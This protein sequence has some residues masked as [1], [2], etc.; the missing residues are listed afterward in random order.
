MEVIK[1][2]AKTKVV[3]ICSFGNDEVKKI[4][5]AKDDIFASPWIS[6]LIKLFREREEVELTIIA[7]NYYNNNYESFRLGKI[8]V[9]LYKYRISRLPPRAYNLTFNYRTATNSILRIVND[10]K[11][12]I[13]HLHGSENPLYSASA[14]PLMDKYPVLVTI[15]GFVSLS[16]TPKNII[17]RYIRWNRIRFE[18]IINSKASYFTVAT[19]DGV[20]ELKRFQTTA[21]LYRD[22]Y[23]TTKPNISSLDFPIKKYDIVYYARLSKA[24]GIEDLLEAIKIL[25]KTRP[26][27]KV[28]V[29]GGGSIKYTQFINSLIE[30]LNLKNN[31]HLAGFQATQQDVFKLAVQAKVYVLP[32]HFDGIPGSLR[33][34]MFMK[35]PVIANAVGGI[36]TLNDEAECVTLVEKLNINDLVDKIQLVLDDDVYTQNLVKNAYNLITDKYDNAKI[37][38]N[39]INIYQDILKSTTK[40]NNE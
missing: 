6:E 37:Y 30:S 28:I 9:Y 36:P 26:S 31:I 16:S 22:H 27:I 40:K 14:I 15:Q 7:P 3:W 12:D 32:T 38:N 8:Q 1:G 34:A 4:V 18:R 5:D 33:E 19:D 39:I 23:P 29:I 25:K 2:V 20:K 24:K 35:I 11:P 10:I 13:V 21:K 17:S